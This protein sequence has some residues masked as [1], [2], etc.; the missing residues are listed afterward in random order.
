MISIWT[1][2]EREGYDTP[3]FEEWLW[4]HVMPGGLIRTIRSDDP[5]DLEYYMASGY[6][7]LGTIGFAADAAATATFYGGQNLAAEYT[8]ARAV[9]SARMI[10]VV[11]QASAPVI[12]AAVGVAVAQDVIGAS[13]GAAT[14]DPTTAKPSWMPL[15]LWLLFQ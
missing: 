14:A 11:A 6:F 15:P 9:W 8:L 5:E 2:R 3:S 1:L 10:P 12:P 4:Y 13:V 7:W